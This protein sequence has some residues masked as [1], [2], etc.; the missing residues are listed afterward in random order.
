MQMDTLDAFM[1]GY[2]SMD[3]PVRSFDWEKAASILAERRPDRAY[4]GLAFALE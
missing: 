4:A 3:D 2:A 1:L